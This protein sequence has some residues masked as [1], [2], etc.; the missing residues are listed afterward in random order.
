MS[1]SQK[2][3]HA[4]FMDLRHNWAEH[5]G[6]SNHELMGG[7]VAFFPDNKA[8]T[9]YLALSTGFSVAGN[10]EELSELLFVLAEEIQYQKKHSADVFK[11]KA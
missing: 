8:L 9:L 11:N 6:K 1:E 7:V 3:S 10:F 2:K 5:G 4:K